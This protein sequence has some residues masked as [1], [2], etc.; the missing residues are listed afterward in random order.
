MISITQRYILYVG[1]C[2]LGRCRLSVCVKNNWEFDHE[3]CV[4]YYIYQSSA[5]EELSHA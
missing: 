2:N 4:L 1:E 5:F 3:C